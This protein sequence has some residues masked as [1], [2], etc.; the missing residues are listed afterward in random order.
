MEQTSLKHTLVLNNYDSNIYQELHSSLESCKRFYFNVAFIS[1]GGLQLFV[2]VLDELNQRGICGEV[3]ASSYLSFTDPKALKKLKEFPNVTLKVHNEEGHGLHAKAYIF[4]YDNSYKVIIGSANITPTALKRNVEWNV[5]IIS[6]KDDPFMLDVIDEF[7]TIWNRIDQVTDEFLD[8][9]EQF[10]RSIRKKNQQKIPHFKYNPGIRPNSMQI[11]AIQNLEKIR[12]YGGKRGLVI[13]AT[14]TG[15]TYMS[16]FDVQQFSPK[17]MLFLVHREDILRK[18]E[19]S[20]RRVLGGLIKTAFFTGNVRDKELAYDAQY[21]F[22]TP[23]SLRNYLDFFEPDEFDYIVLDEAH[24]ASSPTYQTLLN[25]FK[26]DFLLGMTATPERCDNADIFDIFDNNVALEVRLNEAMEDNLVVPFHYFGIND[27]VNYEGVQLDDPTEIAKLLKVNQRVDYIVSQMN[28][29]GFDGEYRKCLGFCVSIDHAQFMAEEFNKRGINSEYLTGEHS[30]S[31]REK[32]MQ[33]LENEKDPLE[34]IFTVDIFNEGIDVPSVNLVLMLR[35]TNSPI[36]FIQQLGRGLRKNPD[37]EYLTV[38]D[39]IGNYNRAFL[40]AIALKGSRYYDKDSLKVSVKNDFKSIPGDTF[41]Q[42]DRISKERI[43][44]QLNTENFNS[45]RYLKEEYLTFKGLMSGHI[46]EFLM[47]YLR[48]DGAPDPIKFIRK[49][50]T[51]PAFLSKME[52]D[53]KYK[54]IIANEEYNKHLKYLCEMLPLKRPYEFAILADLIVKGT[55]SFEECKESILKYL[56]RVDDSSVQHAMRTLNF[57]FYDV[58]QQKLWKPF[59]K[60]VGDQLVLTLPEYSKLQKAYILDVLHYGLARYRNEY[61]EEYYGVPFLKL[62]AQYTMQDTALLCNLEKKFSSFRGQGL[63]TDHNNYF[64]YV[65]LKKDENIKESINYKDRF[66]SPKRF[67]WETPNSTV[68]A[69]KRGKDIIFNEE[70]NIKLHLFVRKFKEI[71]KVIQPYI[72]VGCINTYSYEGNKPITIQTK[73]EH[74]LPPK[75]YEELKT[76]T[77]D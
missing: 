76:D 13:A 6:K 58:S 54:E 35:P 41:I 11:R 43:L 5:E 3:I 62:Y 57:E 16:A 20:F 39:F 24:H 73:L 1:Y 56:H 9:Y 50:K 37:K 21:V 72:Y 34:V 31:E 14:G 67:Q 71:D 66:L 2:K 23:I 51:Y 70:R 46:P 12:K 29:Y 28:L 7:T 30:V 48:Y 26:P 22:A 55:M 65:D 75:I 42:L 77:K 15:K 74:E 10:I 47:D 19:E 63:L 27:V 44:K 52:S 36:I 32:M 69:S 64:L 4:E 49:G 59:V 33:R 8:E 40:I 18:A 25:Y 61:G 38:L 60:Y 68:Q 17:K 45:M 53:L